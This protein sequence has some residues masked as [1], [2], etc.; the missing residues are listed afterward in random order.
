[1]SVCVC[2]CVCVYPDECGFSNG[3]SELE[4]YVNQKAAAAAGGR[5]A[6]EDECGRLTS[7]LFIVNMD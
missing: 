1:M 4:A 6:E 7:G 5:L 2:V 3:P